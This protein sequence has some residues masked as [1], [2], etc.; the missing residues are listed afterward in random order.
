M[1]IMSCANILYLDSYTQTSTDSNAS[2]EVGYGIT[3][4]QAI[5][6]HLVSLGHNLRDLSSYGIQ[7]SSK[8]EWI[9]A[10]YDLLRSLP[11]DKFDVVFI[12]HCF[13]Q[14]PSEVRRIL[15]DRGYNQLKIVGYTHGSHWDPTDTFR[16]IF[17]P[18]MRVTDLA[19]LLCLDR[20]L[21]V[22]HYF[23]KV[24]LK[25]ISAF[26][27]V[28]AA[29]I[30]QRIVVTGLP[31][32]TE[33]IDTNR[34]QT[35][36]DKVQIIFNHSP[37]PGKSPEVFFEIM[38]KILPQH[39]VRLVVTRQFYSDSP[40]SKQLQQLK[41]SYGDQVILGNTMSI[42]D[43][44]QALWQSQIQVS[45]ALHE[46]FGISTV[47][48]MYTH[49]CCILPARQSYPEITDN[50]NL[51]RSEQELIEMLNHY[52]KEQ[53][54]CHQMGEVMHQKSLKYTPEIVV[55]RISQAIELVLSD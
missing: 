15:L 44:Y 16:E 40:G 10:S 38:E 33:L 19:N 34:T 42:A 22:S 26:S 47:E 2:Y 35:K 31:I 37:T 51:Y 9:H 28:A 41:A 43:Y 53:H 1:I 48:A 4:N 52:I 13:N 29:E 45:T 39:D 5:K 55:R 49:N 7:A 11:L 27:Q 17:Y 20:I 25:H 8:L 14:F 32:N 18:G 24:L 23:R 3:V 36:V 12:F 54:K 30:D 6:K 50:T 46:S 21:V